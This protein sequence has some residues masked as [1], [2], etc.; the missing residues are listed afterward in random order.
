VL[1]SSWTNTV[2]NVLSQ[3][4]SDEMS[5]VFFVLT[6]IYYVKDEKIKD[7]SSEDICERTFL[8]ATDSIVFF[9]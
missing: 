4:S 2:K 5:F 9:W 1:N 7:I 3:M 6:Y 8:T